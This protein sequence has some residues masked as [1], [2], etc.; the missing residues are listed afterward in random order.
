MRTLRADD[1][2]SVNIFFWEK[3]KTQKDFKFAFIEKNILKIFNYLGIKFFFIVISLC[4]LTMLFDLV[5]VHFNHSAVL[6]SP[7]SF[8]LEIALF[9]HWNKLSE[10]S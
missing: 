6:I 10:L 7:V 2:E 9:F 8:L 4:S 5:C 3:K 1:K